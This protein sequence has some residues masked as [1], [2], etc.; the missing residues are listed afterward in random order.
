MMKKFHTFAPMKRIL[1]VLF[2]TFLMAA[3]TPI[4]ET[5]LVRFQLT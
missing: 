4:V 5:H 3:C 1:H 2:L